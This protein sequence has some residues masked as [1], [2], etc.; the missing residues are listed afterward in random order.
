MPITD[1]DISWPPHLKVP[2]TL[3]FVFF[4]QISISFKKSF[5]KKIFRNIES[6]FLRGLKV[7]AVLSIFSPIVRISPPLGQMC[8]DMERDVR[9]GHRAKSQ[10][11]LNR[12]KDTLRHLCRKSLRKR[13][14]FIPIIFDRTMYTFNASCFGMVSFSYLTAKKV[15]SIRQNLSSRAYSAKKFKNFSNFQHS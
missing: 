4:W 2:L 8:L 5:S 9:R 12:L 15:S 13:T 7:K 14:Y 11:I 1:M 10:G 6:F 3:Q